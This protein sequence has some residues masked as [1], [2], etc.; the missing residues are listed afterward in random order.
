[1]KRTTI[2][3]TDDLAELLIHEARRQHTSVSELVRRLVKA[4]FG[5]S[6]EGR[7][8]PFASLFRDPKMV[9]GADVD[10]EL[11]KRWAHDIES[12]R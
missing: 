5:V 6:P 7:K 11:K 12:D 8:L 3:L 10:D 1:M 2:T 9:S 4:S